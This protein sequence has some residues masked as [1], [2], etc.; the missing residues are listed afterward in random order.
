[1]RKRKMEGMEGHLRSTV[2][3]EPDLET[4]RGKFQIEIVLYSRGK[5]EAHCDQGTND[6]EQ[7][8]KF[9][10]HYWNWFEGCF[11]P[12]HCRKLNRLQN[13]CDDSH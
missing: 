10:L 12:I 3:G 11:N 8:S 2:R 6:N 9:K 5:V 13:L 4:H 7:L 1:M